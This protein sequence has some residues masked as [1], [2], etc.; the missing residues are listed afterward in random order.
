MNKYSQEDREGKNKFC[1]WICQK[2]HKVTDCSEIKNKAYSEKIN[3]V[4]SKNSVSI[5]FR[6]CMP[7]VTANQKYFSELKSAKRDMIH[8]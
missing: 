2:N 3:L 5:A 1:C 6:T 4:K 7:S 8:F